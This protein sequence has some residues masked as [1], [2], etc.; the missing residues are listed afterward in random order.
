M[1]D[2]SMAAKRIIPPDE[3]SRDIANATAE[4]QQKNVEM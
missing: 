2:S 4:I 3:P 1:P